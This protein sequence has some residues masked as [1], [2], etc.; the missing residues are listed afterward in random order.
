MLALIQ[1]VTAGMLEW[2][3]GAERERLH[4]CLPGLAFRLKLI[5]DVDHINSHIIISGDAIS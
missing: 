4:V 2:A 1:L 5:H 3:G